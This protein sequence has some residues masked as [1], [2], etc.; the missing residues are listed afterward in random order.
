MVTAHPT[1][2]GTCGFSGS[3]HSYFHSFCAVEIQQTFYS[4]PKV[5]TA[6][7]WKRLAPEGFTFT[8][9]AWQGIT[10]CRSS[11]TWKRARLPPGPSLD[12]YG[13]FKPTEEVFGAWEATRR[14]A[15]ELGVSF[16]VMQSPPSF[17]MSAQ[18][19][20]NLDS[21]F[22][23][24]NRGGLTIGWEPRGDWLRDPPRLSRLF[25]RLNLVHVVDPFWDKP[26]SDLPISYFR[27]HG[28]GRRYNYKYEYTGDD[29]HDLARLTSKSSVAG[30]VY[31]MFNVIE[32]REVARRFLDTLGQEPL[33]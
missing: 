29:L 32:M 11:P 5:Q 33:R 10:H 25:S 13:D 19:E 8:M 28:K 26:M 15:R 18:H 4:L 21:F 6:S 1:Y 7:K 22:T 16:I 23:S 2:V 3:M 20:A 12:R 30:P 27:L 24:I 9:K 31:A 14:F 17:K